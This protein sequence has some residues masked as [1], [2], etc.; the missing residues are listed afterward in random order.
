MKTIETG[1]EGLTLIEGPIYPD[2]RGYFIELFK[3]SQYRELLPNVL[4]VQDNLS[5]SQKGVIRGMHLQISPALQGKF[6]R[7]LN[8]EIL[9]VVVDIRKSSK[10][11][12]KWFS[13]NLSGKKNQALFVPPGFLHGFQALE[14]SLVLYK[15]TSE[16]SPK[17]ER[18]IRYDCPILKIKWDTTVDHIVSDKDKILPT[19]DQFNFDEI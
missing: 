18:G 2:S 5:W 16:F 6:V 13:F 19:I 15:C 4:F 9:D 11:F 7:C 12:K 8:G 10:T 17:Q 14:D 1:C 3:T